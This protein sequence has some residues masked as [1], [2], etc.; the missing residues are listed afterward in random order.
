MEN[1]EWVE[2]KGASTLRPPEEKQCE[3][4]NCIV[5]FTPTWHTQRR[6]ERCRNEKRPYRTKD[7]PF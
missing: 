3:A 6:C 1:G 5:K 4:Q 7:S 2:A